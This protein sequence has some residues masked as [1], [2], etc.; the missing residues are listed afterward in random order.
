MRPRYVLLAVMALGVFGLLRPANAA[1][2]SD[3]CSEKCTSTT[4]CTDFC[5]FYEWGGYTTCG[6]AGYPCCNLAYQVTSRVPMGANLEGIFWFRDIYRTD[7]ITQTEVGCGFGG[8][9]TFCEHYN[10]GVCYF[11][12]D[13]YCCARASA[14]G[15]WGADG[16]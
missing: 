10:D 4:V 11:H 2:Q 7:I 8:Q 13:E 3:V 5:Q 16:C 14:F 15:C 1:A 6:E 9:L 12:T